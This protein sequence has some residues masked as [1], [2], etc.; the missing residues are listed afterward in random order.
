VTDELRKLIEKKK[1]WGFLEGRD[2][3]VF[4]RYV[5][6][7]VSAASS[8]WTERDFEQ[9]T[10]WSLG[11]PTTVQFQIVAGPIGSIAPKR[12]IAT[13]G[14]IRGALLSRKYRTLAERQAARRAKDVERKASLRL[15][16][17]A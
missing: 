13:I 15:G 6:A 12:A 17:T 10:R 4:L 14:S 3:L 16:K 7:C 1:H 11:L 2:A 9:L 8:K 5:E